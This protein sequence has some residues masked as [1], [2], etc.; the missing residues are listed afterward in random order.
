MHKDGVT[1]SPYSIKDTFAIARLS[2][3]KAGVE[4]TTPQGTVR[5]TAAVIPGL[6]EWRNSRIEVDANKLPQSMTGERTKYIAAAHGS[7]SEVSFKVLNSRRVMLRIKQADGKPLTK[8]LSVV[9]DKNNYVVTVVDDGHVFLNDADQISA[10]YAVDDDNNRLCKLDFTL[11][12]KH[13][14]DAFYEE[15]TEYVDE[16]STSGCAIAACFAVP[17][18]C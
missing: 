16:H 4:I 5:P 1:F 2:E 15:L 18:L 13:D 11:P 12:E 10:L 7:V 6:T 8:G 14:E 3:P 9:D 17:F